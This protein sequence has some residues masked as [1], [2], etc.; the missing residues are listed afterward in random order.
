MDE[1]ALRAQLVAIRAQVDAI[2]VSLASEAAQAVCQHPPEA[3]R[4]LSVMGGTSRYECRAC[5]AV[6]SEEA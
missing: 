5:G 6:V 3:R 2:L 1:R 4:D